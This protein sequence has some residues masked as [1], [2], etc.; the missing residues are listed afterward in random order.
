MP[1]S[2]IDPEQTRVHLLDVWPE[3]PLY[4][5]DGGLLIDTEGCRANS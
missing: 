5:E 3:G 2:Q 4:K 1:S